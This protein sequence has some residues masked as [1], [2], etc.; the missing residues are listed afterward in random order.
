MY[1]GFV[2]KNI[3]YPVMFIGCLTDEGPKLAH[4]S[5]TFAGSLILTVCSLKCLRLSFSHPSC[6]YV[7]L[8]FSYLFFRL[9]YTSETFVVD[10]FLISI[11]YYKV[12]DLLLKV[13]IL[14][15]IKFY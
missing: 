2:E 1:L 9:E 7:I 8:A 10:Y 4:K 15:W 13:S 6:Q 5:G 14:E 12:Y 11:V 3:I